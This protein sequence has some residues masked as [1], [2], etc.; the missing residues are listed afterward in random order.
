MPQETESLKIW[1][2][3]NDLVFQ[4]KDKLGRIELLSSEKKNRSPPKSNK[5]PRYNYSAMLKA[6]GHITH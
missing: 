5:D 2:E 1:N 4:I 3:S 6:V